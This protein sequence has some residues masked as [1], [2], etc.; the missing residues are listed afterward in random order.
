MTY[1]VTLESDVKDISITV[2]NISDIGA[3]N[4]QL[5]QACERF[6]DLGDWEDY[7]IVAIEEET[8]DDAQ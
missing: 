7:G 1:A 8:T 6:S 4:D 2:H 3:M 5:M